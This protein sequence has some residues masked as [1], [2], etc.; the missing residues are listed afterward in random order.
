MLEISENIA[1]PAHEVE[2]TAVRSRGAGGQKVNKVAS[3]IH[4]RFDIAASESLPDEVKDRLLARRDR[5]ITEDGVVVIKAQRF[6]SQDKN[7]ADALAR[8]RRLL[9]SALHAPPRRVPTK[10][11]RHAKE[12]RLEEK[13][14]RARLKETRGKISD[15]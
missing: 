2:L 8:L 14:R 13:K 9:E 3:A 11:P 15:D 6:R 10:L 5:R 1:I 12:R 7:R 4:L